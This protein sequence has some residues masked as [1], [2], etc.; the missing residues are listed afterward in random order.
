METLHVQE[1]KHIYIKIQNNLEKWLRIMLNKKTSK[2][3]PN[4][5][6]LKYIN[7]VKEIIKNEGS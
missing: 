2:K 7:M 6:Y 1:S 4:S 5:K 3:L